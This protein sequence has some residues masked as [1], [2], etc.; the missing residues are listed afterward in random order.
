MGNVL[1]SWA[2]SLLSKPE[3]WFKMRTCKRATNWQ[4]TETNKKTEKCIFLKYFKRKHIKIPDQRWLGCLSIVGH[5]PL[6]HSS[7]R[8]GSLKEKS[9]NKYSKLGFNHLSRPVARFWG[10][11]GKNTCLGGHDFWFYYILKA[12]FSGNKKILG[13]PAPECPPVATGLHL[14]SSRN[15]CKAYQPLNYIHGPLQPSSPSTLTD[16]R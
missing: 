14:S 8:Y 7:N 9:C 1:V 4:L 13:G 2:N 11:E 12:N 15:V 6:V 16:S 5:V 3:K 10:L